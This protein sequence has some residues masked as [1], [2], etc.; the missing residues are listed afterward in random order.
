MTKDILTEL[1]DA[2][3]HYRHVV[4]YR[5]FFV[6]AVF[7]TCVAIL[8]SLYCDRKNSVNKRYDVRAGELLINSLYHNIDISGEVLHGVRPSVDLVRLRQVKYFLDAGKKKTAMMHLENLAD[9]ACLREIRALSKTMWMGIAL[10]MEQNDNIRKTFL[11]YSSSFK[12][13]RAVLYWRSKILLALFYT[14]NADKK[15]AKTVIDSI[16]LSHKAPSS[17]QQ[18]AK[19]ILLTIK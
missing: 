6:I 15:T 17:I 7:I 14:C 2:K 8:F 3:R 4:W 16:V 5:R 1:E 13:E 19:A 18:E 11:L 12:N 9:N 10:D